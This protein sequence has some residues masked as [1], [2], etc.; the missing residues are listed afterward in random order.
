MRSHSRRPP[1]HGDHPD[2]ILSDLERFEAELDASIARLDGR[3]RN[4]AADEETVDTDALPP[5]AGAPGIHSAPVQ[6]SPIGAPAAQS[7]LA[8]AVASSFAPPA[9]TAPAI[10]VT[11]RTAPPAPATVVR[12]I[13]PAA[14]PADEPDL[15]SE[16]RQAAEEKSAAAAVNES[17][18]KARV[19]RTEKAM[20]ALFRYLGEFCGHL[21]KIQPLVPH[22]FRPLPNLELSALHWTESFIDYRTN[23]GT[24]TS[25]LDTVSLRYTLSAGTTCRIEKLPHYAPAFLDELKRIGLR[26]VANEKRGNRGLIEQVSFTIER[27]L[28]VSLMFKADPEH[29]TVSLRTRHFNGLGN[30]A[31]SIDVAALDRGLFDQ[32]GRHILGRPNQLFQR[33]AQE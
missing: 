22:V 12:L 28:V 11:P 15:L 24:E 17:E 6:A 19:D 20:R 7:T 1:G 2:D 21:D 30:G 13:T 27:A 14:P 26:Y 8:A 3:P 18:R 10:P 25:T 23:G 5:A 16:L 33:I 32:L 31:Y 9:A 4:E 29:E